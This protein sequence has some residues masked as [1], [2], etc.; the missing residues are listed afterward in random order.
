MYGQSM[1]NLATPADGVAAVLLKAAPD[2][3]WPR[4]PMLGKDDP[5]SYFSTATLRPF[6]EQSRAAWQSYFAAFTEGNFAVA[7]CT[8]LGGIFLLLAI[9]VVWRRRWMAGSTLRAV[10]VVIALFALL[11]LLSAV[12]RKTSG[13]TWMPRYV[14]VV[15]PAMLIGMAALAARLPGWPTRVAFL[16]L[17]AAANMVQFVGRT[18]GESEPRLDRIARDVIAAQPRS[19][20][21]S[22]PE[23]VTTRTYVQFPA[24]A[25]GGA[26]GV[27]TFESPRGAYY[28]WVYSGVPAIPRQIL[29]RTYTSQFKIWRGS[30][31]AEIERDLRRSKQIERFIVYSGLNANADDQTD[32]IGD[33]LAGRF[34]RVSDET[35]T[36]YDHW[37]WMQL[38][39][40]RRREYV[41]LPYA[42][43][44]PATTTRPATRPAV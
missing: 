20:V 33:R 40:L 14:A 9:A 8:I 3:R 35:M 21:P 39:R 5:H 37:T 22:Q 44:P 7:R 17:F 23:V 41:K 31:P 13:S 29:N 42:D 6:F 32:A 1:T 30:W 18:F 24:A 36:A 38:Y 27:G 16:V 43:D 10:V 25:F 34:R 15:M 11:T 2:V 19:V 28:L 4:L 26:P 12:P